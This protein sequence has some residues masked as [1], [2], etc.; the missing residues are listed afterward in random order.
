MKKQLLILLGGLFLSASVSA[1]D[2]E[3]VGDYRVS[4]T[5]SYPKTSRGVGAMTKGL[6]EEQL[7]AKYKKVISVTSNKVGWPDEGGDNGQVAVCVTATK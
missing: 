1:E 5:T 4:C 6:I 3:V 7:K 2:I